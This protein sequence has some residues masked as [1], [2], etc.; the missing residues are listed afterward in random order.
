MCTNYRFCCDWL[1]NSEISIGLIFHVGMETL[2]WVLY[3]LIFIKT[4]GFLTS[5]HI[6]NPQYILIIEYGTI[7]GT[8]R[9]RHKQPV[10]KN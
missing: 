3:C 7:Q 9:C 8:G 2:S 10:V 4:I 5:D 1:I 6:S